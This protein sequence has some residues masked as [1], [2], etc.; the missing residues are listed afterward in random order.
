LSEDDVKSAKPLEFVL[1][2]FDIEVAQNILGGDRNFTLVSSVVVSDAAD[3][4][5]STALGI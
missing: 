5:S 3:R 2:Q 1:R 4:G